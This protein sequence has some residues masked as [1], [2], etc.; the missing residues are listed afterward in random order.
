MKAA[1]IILVILV[2]SA[3]IGWVRGGHGPEHIARSLPFCGG[4]KPGL[5]DIG[6]LAVIGLLLW[7]LARLRNTGK[8]DESEEETPEPE[9]PEGPDEEE[10]DAG[11]EES[12]SQPEDPAS[13]QED[14]DG[15]N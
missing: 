11:A 3:L 12:A 9:T 5:Y 2:I 13:D 15:S 10:A 1:K 4:H 8:P 7:G 14:Q 6:G